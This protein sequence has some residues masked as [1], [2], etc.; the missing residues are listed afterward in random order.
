MSDV[1]TC[2]IY[3]VSVHTSD[4]LQ[5]LLFNVKKGV[6]ELCQYCLMVGLIMDITV[7]YCHRSS[8]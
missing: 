5:H 3:Q 2:N 7:L 4:I 6:R 1:C 8:K